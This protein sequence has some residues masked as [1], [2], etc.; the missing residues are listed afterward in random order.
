VAVNQSTDQQAKFSHQAEKEEKE[1]KESLATD[2]RNTL[3]SLPV[4]MMDERRTT[5]RW[6]LNVLGLLHFAGTTISF[7]AW[8]LASFGHKKSVRP[9]WKSTFG[10]TKMEHPGLYLCSTVLFF[11]AAAFC[12]FGRR[13]A[14]KHLDRV[15]V[16]LMLVDSGLMMYAL[17]VSKFTVIWSVFTLILAVL[18]FAAP[19]SL[20]Q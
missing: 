16:L 13:R 12:M 19:D 4:K 18:F 2:R 7:Y 11:M 5:V 9:I 20:M 15:M 1:E 8:R 3:P 6:L 10:D 14:R 17:G